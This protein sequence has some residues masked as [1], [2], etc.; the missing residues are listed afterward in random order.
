[1]T[2]LVKFAVTGPLVSTM[3]CTRAMGAA[4]STR[5][6]AADLSP[7]CVRARDIARWT[8]AVA[9]TARLCRLKKCVEIGMNL[10]GVYRRQGLMKNLYLQQKVQQL[11][12]QVTCA[13]I[14]LLRR[15]LSVFPLPPLN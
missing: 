11:S 1:M 9:T 5:G 8:R 3:E 7:G 10:D 4:A 6:R 12:H 14:W 13:L 15:K 2:K